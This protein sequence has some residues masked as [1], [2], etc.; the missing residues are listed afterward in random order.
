[1]LTESAS[2]VAPLVAK[3]D[4]QLL[5]DY[6]E[7]LGSIRADL[8]KVRQALFNL[9]SNAAKFTKDGTITLSA[10]REQRPEGDR[11]FLSVTDN[12]IGI[13]EDRIDAVFEEFTQA[14]SSTTRNYGGTGLGLPIS[15]R[16]CRMM[17]GD[18]TFVSEVGVGSTFTIE[19]PAK[20]DALEAAR[21]AAELDQEAKQAVAD[22]NRLV[23][24]IDDDPDARDLLRRVLEKDGYAVATAAGGEEGL[25]QAREL[26]PSLITLDV[27]MPG[28]DG[29]AVLQA[30]KADSE[31]QNIPV[32]MISISGEKELGYTLGA[33]D[34]LSKPVD[35]EKLLQ[36]VEQFVDPGEGGHVL[37]IDD[38]ASIRSFL[39]RALEGAGWQAVEAENGAVG[40]ER[41]AQEEPDLILLDLMMPVMD[42][43]EFILQL[44]REEDNWNIPIIVVTAK[45]LT[46]ED[47]QRLVGGVEMIIDKGAYTQDEL[48]DQLR[49]YV[50]QHGRSGQA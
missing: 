21:T 40:L 24:I 35:R 44:R 5:T 38:D 17:G 25:A 41:V 49:S 34:Y 26:R 39:R 22:Q 30:L 32:V 37:I 23:L 45:D 33:V 12:G 6:P 20:V 14:D 31:L 29:W 46:E 16:F 18:I 2:T 9:I 8:T 36:V 3:N 42:G 48:L 19:L 15:R 1:M 47:R 13:P 27:L 28:M 7:N 4:N 43:F 11:I 10:R 50:S